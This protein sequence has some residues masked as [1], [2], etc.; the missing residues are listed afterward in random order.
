MPTVAQIEAESVL[1]NIRA[2]RLIGAVRQSEEYRTNPAYYLDIE[3]VITDLVGA[4]TPATDVIKSQHLSAVVTALDELGDGTVGVK[5]GKYGA[6]YSQSRDR[7]SLV[8]EA[9]GILYDAPMS[10]ATE[11][12]SSGEYVTQQPGSSGCCSRCNYSPCGCRTV[13]RDGDTLIYLW[14][15]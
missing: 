2:Y 10:S 3:T 4:T 14:P 1:T 9:L 6:D 7:E 15:R 8:L 12:G 5:G 13:L 11:D